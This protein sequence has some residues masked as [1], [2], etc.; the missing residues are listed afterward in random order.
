MVVGEFCV[1]GVPKGGDGEGEEVGVEVVGRVRDFAIFEE[2]GGG[3][4][5]GREGGRRRGDG[6]GGEGG[7]GG[8]RGGGDCEEEG[9]GGVDVR[10]F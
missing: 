8:G 6:E 9:G 5:G 7:E 4:G 3:R 10:N 1:G 2:R